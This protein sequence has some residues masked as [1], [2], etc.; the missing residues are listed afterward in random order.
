[1]FQTETAT[2]IPFSAA[3]FTH[4]AVEIF[5]FMHPAILP[6]LMR[7]FGLSPAQAGLIVSVPMFL[8]LGFNIPGGILADKFNSRYLLVASGA[9]SG[10]GALL[11]SQS[12]A[13]IMFLLG[14]CLLMA[15]VTLYHPPGLSIIN[16]TYA[17]KKL[18]KM[19]GIHGATGGIGQALGIFSL[20]LFME[21]YGWRFAYLVWGG[22]LVGWTIILL[23]L[24]SKAFPSMKN[25]DV[26]ENPGEGSETRGSQE[27]NDWRGG[28]F[29]MLHTKEFLLLLLVMAVYGVGNWGVLSYTTT[30]F[31]QTKEMTESLATTLY[32]IGPLISIPAALL[33]GYFGNKVGDENYLSLTFV[34]LTVSVASMT[35]SP[36]IVGTIL[37]FFTFRWFTSSVWPS[38]TSLT[39]SLTPKN[40][41][42][43]AY[44][45]FY[46]VAGIPGAIAPIIVGKIIEIY[47]IYIAFS[48]A[49]LLFLVSGFIILQI[50]KK[51]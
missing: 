6:R 18:T 45:V 35:F 5:L 4:L 27:A 51:K 25:Q 44:S 11:I 23:I 9:M 17:D 42:G 29:E 12:Q 14:L 13:L 2:W 46:T 1:M 31:V 47:G 33:G 32:G 50:K 48:L 3:S 21:N 28:V 37:S 39:G 36:W 10:I 8:R 19:I 15:A 41:K 43:M 49:L 20:S 7:E 30:F 40:V 24:P 22:V 34:G 16:N 26:Q 38:S